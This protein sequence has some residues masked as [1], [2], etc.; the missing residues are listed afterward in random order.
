MMGDGINNAPSLTASTVGIVM[1]MNGSDV[2]VE[3]ADIALMNNNLLNISL[4]IKLSK[5][6]SEDD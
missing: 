6:N 5:K 3:T 2:A 1:G 4:V